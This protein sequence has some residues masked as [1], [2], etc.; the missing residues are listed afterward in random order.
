MKA[1]ALKILT[2]LRVADSGMLVYIARTLPVLTLPVFLYTAALQIVRGGSF[3]G[4]PDMDQAIDYYLL[5]QSL[6]F[7]P[8]FTTLLFGAGVW[9]L[10]RIGVSDAGIVGV[11]VAVWVLIS[12]LVTHVLWL[13][14]DVWL[15][16][17]ITVVMLTWLRKA[18]WRKAITVAIMLLCLHS[19]AM[20]AGNTALASISDIL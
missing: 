18:G 9:V 11:S 20:I 8:V 7:S 6:I 19:A 16:F 1:A 15:Y 17:V 2:T 3:S 5:F 4:L 14:A 10:R 12:G 13:A